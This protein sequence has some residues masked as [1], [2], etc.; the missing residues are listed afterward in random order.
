MFPPSAERSQRHWPRT[1]V[2]TLE[3]K[4]ELKRRLA[5]GEH[6]DQIGPALRVTPAAAKMKAH[7]LGLGLLPCACKVGGKPEPMAAM[8]PDLRSLVA[9]TLA[10]E[11]RFAAAPSHGAHRNW[12]VSWT[13]HLAAYVAVVELGYQFAGAARGLGRDSSLL[14]YAV[15][16]IEDRRDD[17]DFDDFIDR[18]GRRARDAGLKA[19]A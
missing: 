4:A 12:L 18:L 16:R 2:W 5:A 14:R 7:V 8:G 9:A 19:A 1:L 6:Y 11:P 10:A 13:L 15:R 3:K 17:P